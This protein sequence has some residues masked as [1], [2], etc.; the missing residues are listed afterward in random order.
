MQ[1]SAR[2]LGL[3]IRLLNQPL[4]IGRL[5]V[6]GTPAQPRVTIDQCPGRKFFETARVDGVVLPVPVAADDEE[7]LVHEKAVVGEPSEELIPLVPE[8]G[9]VGV[10]VP[11]Q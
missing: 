4:G 7:V 1:E 3:R 11:L 5:R 10:V 6:P 9:G 2:G 8:A